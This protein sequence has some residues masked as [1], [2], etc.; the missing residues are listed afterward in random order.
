MLH[1]E[2]GDI[3]ELIESGVF[4]ESVELEAKRSGGNVPQNAW[5]S[6]SAFANGSGGVLVLGL[7]ERRRAMAGR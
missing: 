6:I 3:A 1:L 2:P 4:E 7:E 5:E